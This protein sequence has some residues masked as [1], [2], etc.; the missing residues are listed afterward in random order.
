VLV[1]TAGDTAEN[2]AYATGYDLIDWGKKEP[3][4]VATDF[5]TT[6]NIETGASD[7]MRTMVSDD[8]P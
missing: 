4:E 5:T 2:A 8:Q 1:Q 7:G 6:R 3:V